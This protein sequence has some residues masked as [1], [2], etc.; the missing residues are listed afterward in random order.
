MSADIVNE[1][2]K[3]STTQIIQSVV[4]E[5]VR[6]HMTLIKSG[7]WLEDFILEPIAP[8]IP[9]VVGKS[10][11]C[12]IIPSINSFISL[13]VFLNTILIFF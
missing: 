7:D 8:M 11:L 4:D 5:M 10:F 12:S 2:V 6:D 9:R 13:F 3:E 1:V